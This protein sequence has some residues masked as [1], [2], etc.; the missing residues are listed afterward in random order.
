MLI[1]RPIGPGA[2]RYYADSPQVGTWVG[3]G[4]RAL[5]LTGP[6]DLGDLADVLGGRHPGAGPIGDPRHPRRRAGWDLTFAAPKGVSVVAAV[7]GGVTGRALGDAHLRAVDEALGFATRHACWVLRGEAGFEQAGSGMVA[8]RFDHPTSA[9]GD[10]HLHTHVLLVN[11]L[12]AE[13]GRWSAVATSPLWRSERELASVYRLGLRHHIG[14]AGYHPAWTVGADGTAD[15]ADIPRPVIT[16]TSRRGAQMAAY[17]QDGRASTGR[18]AAR[19]VTRSRTRVDDPDGWRTAV[20]AAGLDAERAAAVLEAGPPRVRAFDARCVGEALAAKA[21]TFTIRDVIRTIADTSVP[22]MTAPDAEACA[23]RFCD[24][25][26]PAGAGRW[27]TP[28]ALAA[29]SA[30]VDTIVGR[31]GA[32]V[33]VVADRRVEAAAADPNLDEA[34]R[35]AVRQLLAAGRGVDIVAGEAGRDR[36]DAQAAVLDGARRAWQASGYRV[37]TASGGRRWEAVAGIGDQRALD[38]PADILVV[39][40]ADRL[41]PPQ[42]GELVADDR[43]AKVVL[44]EGGTLSLRHRP[45]AAA[46][47]TAGDTLGRAEPG[48]V[49][50]VAVLGGDPVPTAAGMA[51]V[52]SGRDA[53]AH[54]LGVWE[55]AA[56]HRPPLLVGAGPPEVAM[57]NGAVRTRLAEQ[58]AIGG[59]AM[60]AGGREFASGDRIIAVRANQGR[61]VPAASLGTV[62]GVESG[63]RAMTVAWDGRDGRMRIERGQAGFVGYGWATTPA[64][65]ATAGQP[66]A[67]LG[68]PTRAGP[69]RSLVVASTA[70]AP[71]GPRAP[72]RHPTLDA[73]VVAA[74][75]TGT[76][77]SVR[78]GRSRADLAAEHR[79]LGAA[80]AASL[81][82]DQTTATRD[83]ADERRWRT[84]TGRIPDPVVDER[85]ARV[86]DRAATRERW[87]AGNAGRLARWDALGHAID[88]REDLVAHALAHS[89]DGAL[90]AE[91]R[92][93]AALETQLRLTGRDREAGVDLGLG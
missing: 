25:A 12:R 73:A 33:G 19:A 82:P 20:A 14:V 62:T 71:V 68:A 85:A 70:V 90:G 65:A 43:H 50:A 2:G 16:A 15:L 27:T 1:V 52:P 61:R 67:V 26:V 30:V 74:G 81:P 4:A 60:M 40:R 36:L 49:A 54:L 5:G 28:E 63:G 44:V 93:G 59:E 79:R 56:P 10:P 31:A 83:V 17:R 13:D 11:A 51:V 3:G 8:A 37:A 34:G 38:R 55:H 6:V 32:G 58:G 75:V 39:D 80:L 24:G 22:G 47:V 23:E 84:E 45:F 41:T 78:A 18:S 7:V 48:R 76:G 66:V 64:L 46:L 57:L 88:E 21:S 91:R 87:I 89:S 72:Q 92:I 77:G 42:L 29:D 35:A 69:E 86:E 53:V 9:A